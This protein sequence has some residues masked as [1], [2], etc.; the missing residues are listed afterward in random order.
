[1]RIKSGT[2]GVKGESCAK[3]EVV[4]NDTTPKHGIRRE[5]SYEFCVTYLGIHKNAREKEFGRHEK[6]PVLELERL[7]A[8]AMSLFKRV[9]Q[10]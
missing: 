4:L 6:M 5:N 9:L 10:P 7:S 8:H 1:M 3:G 2:G